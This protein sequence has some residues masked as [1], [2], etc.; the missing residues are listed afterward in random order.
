M[1]GEKRGNNIL[2]VFSIHLNL[3]FKVNIWVG[4]LFIQCFFKEN[5]PNEST[6]VRRF[7]SIITQTVLYFHSFF[8]GWVF[9]LPA[10]THDGDKNDNRIADKKMQ[11]KKTILNNNCK[12]PDGYQVFYW[13]NFEVVHFFQG[14][15]PC[16]IFF[17]K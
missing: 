8:F 12:W 6:F 1:F 3:L 17:S 14:F 10:L 2:L 4:V 13:Y 7:F 15:T 16:L 5:N 11:C 9:F